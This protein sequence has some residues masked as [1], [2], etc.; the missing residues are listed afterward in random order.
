LTGL[1]EAVLITRGY[2]SS[3]GLATKGVN[4]GKGIASY[5]NFSYFSD[6]IT[7]QMVTRGW[8]REIVHK[9]INNP[10]TTREAINKANGNPA[11]AYFTKEGY[12]VVKDRVTNIIIK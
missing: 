8:S 7:K 4:V 9:T 1:A 10:Y 2:Y 5:S 6:K 12:Y 11:T 3:A